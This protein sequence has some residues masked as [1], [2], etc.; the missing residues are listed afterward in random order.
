MIKNYRNN[1]NSNRRRTFR[2]PDRNFRQNGS[3]GFNG[4][5]ENGSNGR[6]FRNG[7][8]RGNLN[9][10]KLLEKYNNL[11][12]EALNNGDKVL[13]ETYYQHADHY[14]RITTEQNLSREKQK[15]EAISDNKN[16]SS[17]EPTKSSPEA[18]N[19]SPET[20]KSNTSDK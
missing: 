4:N 8:S 12:T 1:N 5:S 16:N 19:P 2:S 13:S 11:A 18:T 17:L 7:P 10:T 9:A 20:S 14:L 15:T 6:F 3:N